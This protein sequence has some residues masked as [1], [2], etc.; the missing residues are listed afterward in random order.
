MDCAR[1]HRQMRDL[2]VLIKSLVGL[3]SESVRAYR[4]AGVEWLSPWLLAWS[5]PAGWPGLG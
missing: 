4:A 5:W 1:K 3:T 2:Y